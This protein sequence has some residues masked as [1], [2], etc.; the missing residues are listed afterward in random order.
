MATYNGESYLAEQIESILRQ[1]ETRWKLIIQDD[2]STDRS[3]AV[4]QE[5]AEQ[6]P[7]AEIFPYATK[8]RVLSDCLMFDFGCLDNLFLG[9]KACLFLLLMKSRM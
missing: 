3:A 2:C 7:E 1:T 4:A 6:Y 8:D 5:Y 9:N